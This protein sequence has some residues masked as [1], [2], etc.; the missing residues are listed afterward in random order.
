MANKA[1]NY[2][3]GRGL[4]PYLLWRYNS[5]ST[6]YSDGASGVFLSSIET[7]S[8]RGSS[9]SSISIDTCGASSSCSWSTTTDHCAISVVLNS[10]ELETNSS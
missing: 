1:S 8:T 2:D 7:A 5:D 3:L 6:D 9:C 4:P 10:T